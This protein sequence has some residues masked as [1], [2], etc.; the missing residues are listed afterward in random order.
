MSAVTKTRI[1]QYLDKYNFKHSNAGFMIIVDIIMAMAKGEVQRLNISNAYK[2][3]AD[4]TNSSKENVEKSIRFAIKNSDC[5]GM[6]N[7]EFLCRAYDA[8]VF[9]EEEI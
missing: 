3:V 8:I 2:K 4:D 5:S 9:D 6:T 7:K 1:I